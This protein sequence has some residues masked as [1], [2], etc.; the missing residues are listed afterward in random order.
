M[1]RGFPDGARGSRQSLAN[2]RGDLGVADLIRRHSHR[3][4]LRLRTID[5]QRT[6]H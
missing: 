2:M 4:R 3:Q 1:V 6:C 5:V